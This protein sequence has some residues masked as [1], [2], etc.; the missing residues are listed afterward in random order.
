MTRWPTAHRSHMRANEALGNQRCFRERNQRAPMNKVDQV[1]VESCG[2]QAGPNP[3]YG[4]D[5]YDPELNINQK[6]SRF[7]TLL[8]QLGELAGG[9]D[10]LPRAELGQIVVSALEV[11]GFVDPIEVREVVAAVLQALEEPEPIPAVARLGSFW[12]RRN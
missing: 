11:C 3:A 2:E 4:K 5:R 7:L 6:V 12:F 8:Q 10:A 1:S 9:V